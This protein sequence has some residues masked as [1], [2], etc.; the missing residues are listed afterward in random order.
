[1]LVLHHGVDLT[2]FRP[3]VRDPDVSARRLVSVGRLVKKKGYVQLLHAIATVRDAGVA[4]SLDIYGDGPLEEQL[5]ALRD[6]LVL[7]EQ[8]RFLGARSNE[9]IRRAL[10]DADAFVLT[11]QMTADG[12]RDGIPNVLVEAMACGLPVVTT[13]A[14]GITELVR[15]ERNGLVCEPGD[16]PAMAAS[17]TRLLTD[18][19]LRATL[20]AAARA[21]VEAGYDV[22]AAAR[23]MQRILLPGTPA[24]MEVS[25]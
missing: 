19:V 7:A 18:F 21:T 3:T 8:I 22:D 24:Q 9:R 16:V 11:P 1:V 12:D 15:H 4:F 2:Q 6:D 25:R 17:V 20:G 5:L 14:G 13:S 10:S 23:E